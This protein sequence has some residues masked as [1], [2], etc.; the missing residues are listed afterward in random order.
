MRPTLAKF[1]LLASLAGMVPT[2]LHATD[3]CPTA[4]A[5]AQ[6]ALTNIF[7][8]QDE[9]DELQ[10]G[11]RGPLRIA[12]LHPDDDPYREHL[13]GL[14]RRH[15]LELGLYPL[16][17]TSIALSE[18]AQGAAGYRAD[19]VLVSSDPVWHGAVLTALA[20]TGVPAAYVLRFQHAAHGGG[21]DPA[22][23]S[24]HPGT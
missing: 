16:G 2:A 9:I 14:A 11:G 5:V 21:V 18:T 24:G 19:W 10:A 12:F 13:E 3:P 8:R 15:G 1:I 7:E 22:C 6:A 23:S 17:R 4:S 20:R